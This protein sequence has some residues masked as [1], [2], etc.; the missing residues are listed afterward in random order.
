MC[1]EWENKSGLEEMSAGVQY[2]FCPLGAT[3]APS[4]L[5]LRLGHPP[6]ISPSEWDSWR[7]GTHRPWK[8]ANDTGH[9]FYAPKSNSSDVTRT[10]LIFSVFPQTD[11]QWGPHAALTTNAQYA[12]SADIHIHVQRALSNMCCAVS[13]AFTGSRFW[14]NATGCP[15]LISWHGWNT[16][17]SSE[18]WE[19]ASA[20]TAP[21]CGRNFPGIVV[22]VV[23][24]LKS[25]SAT[26]SLPLHSTF[27][28]PEGHPGLCL[29]SPAGHGDES[30]VNTLRRGCKKR[31]EG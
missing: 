26:V 17:R 1:S 20:V 23:V 8:R 7:P 4:L 30:K 25:H 3:C 2:R 18:W 31:R 15:R 21:E 10:C 5:C 13:Y 11:V 12:L 16:C 24:V 9:I 27:V 14:I 6:H 19:T 22:V 29:R 28:S